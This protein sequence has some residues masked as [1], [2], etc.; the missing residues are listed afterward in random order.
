MLGLGTKQDLISA[1]I[2]FMRACKAKVMIGC[3]TLG[4]LYLKGNGVPVNKEK[5][6]LYYKIVCDNGDKE[7]CAII[8]KIK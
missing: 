8:D 3:K 6:I 1:S 2:L 7:A 5:A 4:G